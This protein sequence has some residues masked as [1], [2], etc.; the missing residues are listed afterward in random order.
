[1]PQWLRSNTVNPMLTIYCYLRH[2][3]VGYKN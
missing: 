1:M 2:P 3:F